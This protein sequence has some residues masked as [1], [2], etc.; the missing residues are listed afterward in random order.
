M[1][2]TVNKGGYVQS[3]SN[4]HGTRYEHRQIWI[5]HNGSIPHGMSIHHVNGNKQDNRIENLAL[6][7]HRQ[8]HQKMDRAGKGYAYDKSRNK[9]QAYRT[10]EGKNFNLGRFVTKC[11][12]YM[13][14]KM[15]Y[16]THRSTFTTD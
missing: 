9:Y 7:T 14:S 2:M 16:I 10:I 3:S 11:G 13:A 4:K 15:A 8:N 1:K 12:A 5:Q 6:V